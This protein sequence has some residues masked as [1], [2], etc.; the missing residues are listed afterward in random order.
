MPVPR[1]KPHPFSRLGSAAQTGYTCRM[2][3]SQSPGPSV[4]TAV[5]FSRAQ[6]LACFLLAAALDVVMRLRDLPS[7]LGGGFLNPDSTMRMLRLEE[8]VRAHT[9]LHV[10]ARD[11]SGLGTLLHWSHFLDAVLLLLSSPFLPFL[12]LR[13]ALHAGGV[14]L[15]P[16][17][18]GLLGMALAWCCA[19]IAAPSRRWL[20]AVMA[21]VSVPITGYGAAGVVHHHIPVAL[22]VVTT[23]G[24]AWRGTWQGARAGLRMGL[25]AA[26]GILLT[27]ESMPFILMGFGG[28]G[29]V[30][31]A[32]P[33]D[34]AA[35]HAARAAG[36][37][38]LAV[39][40]PAWLID[41]P[42]AGLAAVEIDRL[43]L[44]WV[45]FALA[46][47][48]I[49][50]A[51]AALDRPGL[52]LGRSLAGLAIAI[53]GLAAWLAAFPA[54]AKGPDGLMSP[55]MARAFFSQ[56]Q[57]MMPISTA[58]EALTFLTP[59]VVGLATL[60][61]LAWRRRAPLAL[62]PALC[63]A[64]ALGLAAQHLRFSTYPALVGAASLPV[65]LTL[66]GEAAW[67]RLALLGLCLLV[68]PATLAIG[69][70]LDPRPPPSSCP[71][72][73]AVPLLADHA[74]AV[75]M[76]D[77]NETPEL[78]YLT[79]VKTVGS[80]YHRNAAAFIRLRDAWRSPAS[81]EEP[82]AV[83]ATGAQLILICPSTTRSAL[84]ADLPVGT[85]R[86]ALD[87]GTPPDWL[88]R[89]GDTGPTGYVLY[90]L[91]GPR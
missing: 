12:P 46:C 38:L 44:V 79:G 18:T 58:T 39:I 7:V 63:A 37:T 14:L 8:S 29:L 69:A 32:R 60:L 19:P 71:V 77:P 33:G 17:A 54:V 35:G 51:L 61:W 72:A 31:L 64:V 49:G 59:G 36:L 30:W 67:L 81:P 55:E 85:L 84:V 56:I 48:A 68:P 42:Y 27:P 2:A 22:A 78:L 28:L 65:G 76:A 88:I 20:A 47:A 1:R 86:D 16:M 3:V 40:L 15:G 9:P 57:E 34:R 75:V 91:R 26:A 74:G 52:G 82:P 90:R 41:P 43:S 83:R 53:A 5:P 10:V 87:A 23:L 6:A 13:A 45:G 25:A 50:T 73:T 62:Y 11:G 80:L 89:L 24:F 70:R 4:G 66:A 21:G